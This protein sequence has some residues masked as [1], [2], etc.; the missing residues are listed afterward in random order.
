[1]WI[2]LDGVAYNRLRRSQHQVRD[3][4][5]AKCWCTGG[6][7]DRVIYFAYRRTVFWLSF[8]SDVM[9]R[10]N[11]PR[12]ANRRRSTHSATLGNI[13]DPPSHFCIE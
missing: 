8:D 6:P 4:Y 12:T 9:R 5:R 1:M 13:G 7:G 11:Q 3:R 2:Q 10:Y